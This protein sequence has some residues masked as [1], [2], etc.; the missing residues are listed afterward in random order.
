MAERVRFLVM[1]DIRDPARLRRV[2]QVAIDHGERLQYSVYVC[3]LTRQ[4]LVAF[5]AK[6]RAE[7][8]LAVDSV[9]IFDLGPAAKR[10]EIRVE[11]LGHMVL[12]GSADEDAAEVW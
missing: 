12:A 1:Y 4:E 7:L 11:H 9:S 8:N 10:R 5:R 2:H 6:L 3:D